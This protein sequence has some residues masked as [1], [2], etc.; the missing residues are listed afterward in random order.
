MLERRNDNSEGNKLPQWA[1]MEYFECWNEGLCDRFCRIRLKYV[2]GTYSNV[3][4][5]V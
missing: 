1:D 4:E 2:W 3:K 5:V